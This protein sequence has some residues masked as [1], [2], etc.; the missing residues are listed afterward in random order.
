[1]GPRGRADEGMNC[2]GADPAVARA[3]HLSRPPSA[4]GAIQLSGYL[5]GYI[6]PAT[7][8]H[9]MQRVEDGSW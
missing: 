4:Q 1:M 8:G 7:F 2:G 5:V 6:G 9:A 3:T